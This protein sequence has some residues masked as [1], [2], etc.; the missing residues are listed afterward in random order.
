MGGWPVLEHGVLGRV[1]CEHLQLAVV[2]GRCWR[3]AELAERRTE[4]TAH[5]SHAAGA[6]ARWPRA[7]G[8]ARASER[9]RAAVDGGGQCAR[10]VQ[11]GRL[12]FY[13][14]RTRGLKSHR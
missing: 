2:R 12:K 13:C 1:G 10:A 6:V 8:G 7:G 3:E 14:V 11:G 4:L 9:L 5:G